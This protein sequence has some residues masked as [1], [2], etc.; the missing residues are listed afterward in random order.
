[1]TAVRTR[2][3]IQEVTENV[4]QSSTVSVEIARDISEVNQSAGE[5]ARGSE[6][7][8]ESANRLSELA[9]RQENMV[10]KFKV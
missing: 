1:M 10:N 5:M 9:S 7:V 3:G 8:N 4:A 2:R 6:T